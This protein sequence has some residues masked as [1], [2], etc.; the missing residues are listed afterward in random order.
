MH[1]HIRY[2]SYWSPTLFFFGVLLL[3]HQMLQL[4]QTSFPTVHYTMH[5]RQQTPS[6]LPMLVPTETE[7]FSIDASMYIPKGGSNIVT[8]VPDDCIQSLSVNGQVI[9]DDRFP[10]CGNGVRGI[11][12]NLGENTAHGWNML[13][14]EITDHGGYA[15]FSISALDRF[16]P[17]VLFITASL[18]IATVLYGYI[19]LTC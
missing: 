7:Q 2:I 15:G 13:H 9:K 18:L 17:I 16:S 11:L 8:I 3:L 1:M 6:A 14:A 4:T 12:I 5:G 19:R 10:F